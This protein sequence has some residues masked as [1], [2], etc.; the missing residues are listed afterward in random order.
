MHAVRAIFD[1]NFIGSMKG[2]Q[3]IKSPESTTVFFTIS[4]YGT[5]IPNS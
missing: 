4:L 1:I 3:L 5:D 2:H